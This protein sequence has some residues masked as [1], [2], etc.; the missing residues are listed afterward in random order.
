MDLALIGKY[1]V[2]A[3]KPICYS[4]IEGKPVEPCAKAILH[5]NIHPGTNDPINEIA[6]ATEEELAFAVESSR[7]AFATW[8]RWTI[9]QRSNVLLNAARLLRERVEQLA[10]LEVWDTGKPISEALSV[11]VY[12]AADALEYFAKAALGLEDRVIPDQNA[13]IYTLR[14]PLGVCVGIGAWNYPLQIACWKAAPALIMGNTLVFKPSELTPLTALALAEL[15]IEAGMPAGVFNV[16]LGDG[17]VAQRLLNQPHIAKISFTGSVPTGKK[18]LQQAANQIIPVTLELGGKSPLI[19]F[20]DASLD[21]AVVGS[22]LA[23]F[24]TQGEICSNGT[25]VYV[26]RSLHDRF[27]QQLIARIK[28]LTIGNPFD[29]NTQMGALISSAHLNKVEHYVHLAQQEGAELM[30]GGRKIEQEPLNRGNFF[31]P[32]LFTQCNDGMCHVQEEIFGPL[33]SILTFDDEE[34]V[35]QRANAS[36]YGLAAGLFTQNIKRGHRVAKQMQAGVCWINNYNVTPLAMPFG[37]LKN[38]GLGKENGMVT[39]LSYTQQ[40]SIYVELNEISHSYQ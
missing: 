21:D 23:N 18:I 29:P 5:P 17:G 6:Y 25:R 32:T 4:F 26:A 12:S 10:N 3:L 11:D 34:E 30:F 24:Y 27:V 14:E 33:M 28:K 15:F 40:K 35:I 19:I 39:L 38:S 20:D 22:M 36:S 31:P 8:S 13:L 9:N 37:G 2:S 1:S 16:V 7:K